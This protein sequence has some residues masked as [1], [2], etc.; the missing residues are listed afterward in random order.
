MVTVPARR[1]NGALCRFVS[2]TIA[3]IFLFSLNAKG[4]AVVCPPNI[5][6]SFGLFT[7]WYCWTGASSPGVTSPVFASPVF[8][9]APVTGRHLIT[10]GSG[11]DPYGLFSVVAPGGGLFS[12]KLGN[13]GSGGEAERMQF[14][15]RVPTG[16]NNYSFAYKYAVVLQLPN[17][18]HNPQDQPAFTVVAYDSATG[19]PIPCATITYVAAA[20]LPGFMTSPT[21]S[22]V[23]Y[24]PWTNGTLNLSGMGGKTVIVEVTSYDCTQGAHFGYGYFDIVSCG[25]FAATIQ[26]CNLAAGYVTLQAP[27][28]YKSYKWFKGPTISGAP[29][30]ASQ[31]WNA[32]IPASCIFYYCVLEPYNSNG[33]P[34]TIRTRTICNFSVDATPDTV[35]NALG[36]P[37]Q[38][39][40]TAKGGLG[41][42]NY[43]W[44]PDPTLSCTKCTNPIATPYGSG[45][46]VV[47]VSDSIGCFRRDTVVIQN[48]SFKLDLGPDLTT[49]LGTPVNLKPKLG[50]P[51]AGYVFRW[52]DGAKVSDSTV[53]SPKFTPYAL[54][55][56]TLVLRVD[57]GV[58][59]TADTMT[60]R[61]L[62][63]S[64]SV[65]DTA[66][67]EGAGFIP[68]VTGDDEFKYVWTP[69]V[70]T[71]LDFTG[72]PNGRRPSVKA[73]TTR[74]FIVT[75]KY[76]TCPDIVR[77]ITFRVEPMPKVD[78]GFDSIQK[79]FY[80]PLYQTAHVLPGWYTNYTYQ[81]K[82]ND[83]I[84]DVNSP[85]I[86]YT[87]QKDTMLMV[88][89]TTPL[90]CTGKD[91]VRV[92]V[93]EGK[94][95]KVSP[96]DTGICPYNPVKM[97]ASGG[98]SYLW[99]PSTY[100]SDSTGSEVTA[101]AKTS[102]NYTLYVTDKNGCVDTM[103]VDLRVFS[104]ASVSVP[105]SI[106]L[107]PGEFYQMNPLGNAHY[108]TWFPVNGLS[109][110]S[111]AN[112]IATP[113]VNTRYFVTGVTETGCVATDSIYVMVHE[114]SVIDIPN[115]F[116]P[117]MAPNSTFNVEHL[118]IANL[119]SFRIYNR[120]GTKVFETND[121]SKGWDGA[122]NGAPQPVGI[123]VFTVEATTNKGKELKKQGNVTLL[124]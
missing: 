100:L 105:D 75:A 62:P 86:T 83:F 98:V 120:W 38:L 63:N 76:P 81:W 58:C 108:F 88:T 32:L 89:V 103:P 67:C 17:P 33:C 45:F 85:I 101:R 111:A 64:F 47:T 94:F 49:C 74:T 110:P 96:E 14:Y 72:S 117:G 53:L 91:S 69:N 41:N 57:S 30:S 21:A 18:P 43:N 60:I 61:T 28:G 8:T 10:S 19:L 46:Y 92:L 39:G 114:E 107:Y 97:K 20:G 55:Y 80:T 113:T 124:R 119:K 15:V 9:G 2:A 6:F 48:P 121:I 116:T 26:Y 29:V 31:N 104:E 37:I 4:Q 50:P 23:T 16:F 77:N 68:H 99:Q 1:Q 40:V 7:N 51:G 106:E 95:A 34:D 82:M 112:P 70:A 56:D 93:Y 44:V 36:N 27:A 73:D 54:G 66:V 11:V 13:D 102:M 78:L 12:A 84:D 115:A 109:N 71:V 59:A 5:D 3:L 123:Y 52:S 87:G 65:V 35:C 25:E 122:F 118:G 79:C 24:L 90:G 42:F 22:D